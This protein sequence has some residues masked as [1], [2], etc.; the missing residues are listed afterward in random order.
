MLHAIWAQARGG[1]IGADG[2]IPWDVPED[3]D[4]FKRVTTGGVV[5]MGRRTWES[6]PAAPLPARRNIV[7]TRNP[8]YCAEGAE[9]FGSLDEALAVLDGESAWVIG[10]EEIYAAALPYVD[11]VYVTEIDEPVAGD[12]FAPR[13]P[14]HE[15]KPKKER[16][17][18][19]SKTGVKYRFALYHRPYGTTPKTPHRK[20]A[21]G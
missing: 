13:L 6:L 12:T 20:A 8:D 1:V 11:D 3:R 10:G 19:T 14:D 9:V 18:L 21:H 4:W 16:A 7:I 17:W 15:W 5:I 2:T